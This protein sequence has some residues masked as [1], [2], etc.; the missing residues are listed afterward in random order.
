M[1]KQVIYDLVS[2]YIRRG[3]QVAVCP[4]RTCYGGGSRQRRLVEKED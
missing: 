1:S 2:D 3:G 4:T